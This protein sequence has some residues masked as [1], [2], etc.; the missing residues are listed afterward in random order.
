MTGLCAIIIGLAVTTIE[1]FLAF[2]RESMTLSVT[3][4]MLSAFCSRAERIITLHS[5]NEINVSLI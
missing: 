5:F 4:G 1:G 2:E 3:K